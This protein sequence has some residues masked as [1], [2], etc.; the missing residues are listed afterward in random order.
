M[1][2]KIFETHVMQVQMVISA[3][4]SCMFVALLFMNRAKSL[5]ELMDVP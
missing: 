5:L 3:N 1:F 4:G 2:L